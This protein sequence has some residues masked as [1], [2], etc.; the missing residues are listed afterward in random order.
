MFSV[1]IQGVSGRL[2]EELQGLR[3][4]LLEE[5]SDRFRKI[6]TTKPPEMPKAKKTSTTPSSRTDPL[7][8][9]SANATKKAKSSTEKPSGK[10]KN[11]KPAPE[12]TGDSQAG[13]YLLLIVL[14][15][16]EDPMI[17]RL[18][19]IPPDATFRKLH[20]AIQISFGW[21]ECHMHQF[22]V[23]DPKSPFGPSLLT[24]MDDPDDIDDSLIDPEN[25]EERKEDK[26]VSLADVFEDGRYKGKTRMIYEYDMGDSWE[27]EVFL[28]GRADAAL[29]KRMGIAQKIV[30]V[31]GEGHG[32]AEDCGGATGW[33]GLK[34]AFA[35]PKGDKE[36]KDW[37]K[38]MCTN[39][40]KKG[41]DPWKWDIL[42]INE[43]LDGV[44]SGIFVGCLKLFT[45][46]TKI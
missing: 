34:E 30:C 11:T 5:L 42:K 3:T 18:L 27:Y 8:D 40:D 36:L 17:Q 46:S 22:M 19:S 7:S 28:L 43:T 16:T 13:N 24:M 10:A 31:A 35:K 14:N 9:K 45:D 2:E 41:L 33:E 4:F 32:C 29:G 26:E 12:V 37:Y 20:Q 1:E 21:A 39:G 38:Y 44:N 25:R 23:Q 15:N 6:T